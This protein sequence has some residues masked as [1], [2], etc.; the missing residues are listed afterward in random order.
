MPWLV[1]VPGLMLIRPNLGS[2]L[3]PLKTFRRQCVS[4]F[5]G[6]TLNELLSSVLISVC[7]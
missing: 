2:L 6:Q 4:G 7:F 3:L 1:Y 5:S